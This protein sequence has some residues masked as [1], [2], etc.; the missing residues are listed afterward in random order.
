MGNN[1]STK[2]RQTIEKEFTKEIKPFKFDYFKLIG[3]EKLIMFDDNDNNYNSNESYFSLISDIKI[4]QLLCFGYLRI[5]LINDYNNYNNKMY[6][7]NDICNLIN[8][9]IFGRYQKKIIN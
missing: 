5:I 3:N 7:P 1:E 2:G 9:Y 8:K 6:I 4:I